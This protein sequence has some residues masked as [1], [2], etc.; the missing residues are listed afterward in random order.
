M[1]VL[2]QRIGRLHRHD[3]YRPQGFE[4]PEVI[5]LT[6]PN[7]DA[8][9]MAT[10]RGRNGPHGLGGVVYSDLIILAATRAQIGAGTT[11]IIPQMNRSLVEAATHPV[12][13]DV[14]AAQLSKQDARWNEAR[15]RSL[16]LDIARGQAA[17]AAA[18]DWNSPVPDFRVA[19]ERIGT[20]LGLGDVE[21][22]LPQPQL[23]PFAGSEP[24]SRLVVPAHLLSGID[25]DAE[26]VH[27]SA[28]DGGFSFSLDS[29]VF[30]YDQYGLERH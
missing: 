1:D 27:I 26:P 25:Y 19:E 16:G 3:R 20:R 23:G 7:F 14:L 22:N 28:T 5:V 13:I 15:M 24:I 29:A 8:S 4:A 30:F 10:T 12:T 2:L 11:W 21:I 9:L 6:P 17:V 18:I